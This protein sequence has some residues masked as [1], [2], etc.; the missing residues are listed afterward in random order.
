MKLDTAKSHHV[1]HCLTWLV[2]QPRH[3]TVKG[4]RLPWSEGFDHMFRNEWVTG[5]IPSAPP[6][7][8]VSPVQMGIRRVAIPRT[9]TPVF[10]LSQRFAT[11]PCQ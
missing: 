11:A 10:P 9:L 2:P 5:S 8:L 3:R 7:A 4:R 6:N 1:S